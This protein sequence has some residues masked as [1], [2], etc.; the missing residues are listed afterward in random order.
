MHY[1]TRTKRIIRG[2]E[3]QD[4]Y[5]RWRRYL[6]W[7]RH[8][9]MKV[10]RRTHKRERRAGKAEIRMEVNEMP[11]T[12]DPSYAFTVTIDDT[13]TTTATGLTKQ[14]AIAAVRALWLD[15]GAREPTTMTAELLYI[16]PA[17][18]TTGTVPVPEARG[19]SFAEHIINGD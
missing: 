11:E 14:H 13:W 8:E 10:K 17:P 6:G 12:P 2:W 18:D 15:T 3:E 9:R 19:A 4:A 7:Q 1:G 5:T 16:G